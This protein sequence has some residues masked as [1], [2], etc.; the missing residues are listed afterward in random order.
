MLVIL[1][2]FYFCFIGW[3]GQPL[4]MKHTAGFEPAFDDGRVWVKPAVK[5][6]TLRVHFCDNL[7]L[8]IRYILLFP[9]SKGK[10]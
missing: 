6:M 10:K 7:G 2:P 8:S 3:L 4:F 9:K 5:P 1:L